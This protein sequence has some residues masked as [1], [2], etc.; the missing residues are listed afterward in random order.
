MSLYLALART[1]FRRMVAYRA[2][3]LAGLGTNFFFGLL[4]AAI[5]IALYRQSEAASVAGYSL[6]DAITYTGLTQALIAPLMIWGSYDIVQ[7]IRTGQI[8]SDLTRPIDFHAFWLAQDLGRSAYNGLA[9]GL[10][11]M[12]A[13]AVVFDLTWPAS[14]AQWLAFALSVVL[15]LLVSF[16]YRFIINLAAF[17]TTDARGIERIAYLAALLFTGLVLPLAFF[18]DRLRE[19]ARLSPFAAYMNTPAE[20][21]LGI[22]TGRAL[23]LALGMQLFWAVV[24]VLAGRALYRRGIRR[25]MVQGG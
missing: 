12:L 16:G 18:P 22:A 3:T 19:I 13:Y 8:A 10:T 1:S 17:W 15:A 2:A 14:A 11:V 24:F 23:W 6:Q 20:V 25:L 9:R 21:Y 7:S 5:F 4:R